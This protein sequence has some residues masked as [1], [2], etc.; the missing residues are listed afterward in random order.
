MPQYNNFNDLFKGIE[1]E[2]KKNPNK[3]LDDQAKEVLAGE[4]T[5]GL[6]PKCKSEQE[7]QILSHGKVKCL[8]CKEEFNLKIGWDIK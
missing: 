4:K 7:V 5:T 8:K 1:K 6:C 2:L 3:Y